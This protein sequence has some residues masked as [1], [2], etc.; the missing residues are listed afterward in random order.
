MWNRNDHAKKGLKRVR[1]PEDVDESAFAEWREHTGKRLGRADV[2]ALLFT[3]IPLAAYLPFGNYLCALASM[4][5]A[6]KS[7]E[8]GRKADA[9]AKQLGLKRGVGWLASKKSLK[10]L[11]SPRTENAVSIASPTPDTEPQANMKT[12]EF[13][14]VIP[15]GKEI[16]DGYVGMLH[17]TPYSLLL[18]NR[19]RVRCDAEVVIDGTPV[20]TWRINGNDEIRIERPVNDTGHFTFFEVGSREAHIAGITASPENGLISVTFKPEQEVK[21]SPTPLFS[22]P[23]P[24]MA[25][26]ATGQ[27][28]ESR[29]GSMDTP[30]KRHEEDSRI[31]LKSSPSPNM[32]ADATG[33]TSESRQGS[34]DTP[35]KRHEE[36]S[37]FALYSSPSPNV[38]AGATGLTGES[39]QRFSDVPAI[40]HDMARIFTIHIRLVSKAQ[41]IR[42]LA[43]R[44]TPVP[45][46]VG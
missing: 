5:L 33:Q 1:L 25:P 36:N 7:N 30:S 42:P 13:E 20:G 45:P 12:T 15:E 32:A 16:G 23:S 40:R 24:N 17:N 46:P 31:A 26:D 4:I 11:E 21:H 28:S 27:T 38:A 18:R 39:R 29:Q 6:F 10:A 35:A 34:T 9:L 14:V 44:S 22:S 43:P 2:A 41:D 8:A 37:R 19:L 3:A